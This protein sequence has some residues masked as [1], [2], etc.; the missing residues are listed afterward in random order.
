M[1]AKLFLWQNP[2]RRLFCK[3]LGWWHISLFL[4]RPCGV[5]NINRSENVVKSEYP[6][7]ILLW[8]LIPCIK[9]IS[10]TQLACTALDW[11]QYQFAG[12]NQLQLQL[13]K[14]VAQNK[15]C[16]CVLCRNGSSLPHWSIHRLSAF[17][18]SSPPTTLISLGLCK[19]CIQCLLKRPNVLTWIFMLHTKK[20]HSSV[21][22]QCEASLQFC[23]CKNI[24]RPSLLMSACV[25]VGLVHNTTYMFVNQWGRWERRC[26]RI[27]HSFKFSQRIRP[28]TAASL[29]NDIGT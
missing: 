8:Q 18:A 19:F 28:S 5:C 2:L 4:S 29:S 13:D 6:V 3:I 21:K 27:V 26:F 25:V 16:V 1:L 23:R 12:R 7:L 24:F 17:V 15:M 22:V 9:Y 10:C 20:G 14:I 11:L